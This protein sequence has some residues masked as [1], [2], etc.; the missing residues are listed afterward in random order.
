MSQAQAPILNS[1]WSNA[2]GWR[3]E[4]F[5]RIKLVVDR[6]DRIG[7]W[8][9]L[10]HLKQA[11]RDFRLWLTFRKIV[12]AKPTAKPRAKTFFKWKKNKEE[13]RKINEEVVEV[14]EELRQLDKKTK[15]RKAYD[16]ALEMQQKGLVANT[17]EALD[18]QVEEM[19]KF[20]DEALKSFEEVIKKTEAVKK[21]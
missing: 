7:F 5:Y 17:K 18:A 10:F 6:V 8:Y 9:Y 2:S 19:L 21:E 15:M 16:V 13:V 14:K 11:L 20:D 4:D 1:S 3:D 12:R